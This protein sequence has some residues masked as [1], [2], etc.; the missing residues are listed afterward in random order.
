MQIRFLLITLAFTLLSSCA[1]NTVPF[2]TENENTWLLEQ[3]GGDTYPIYCMA[4]KKN[5]TADPV[6]YKARKEYNKKTG[7]LK[8]HSP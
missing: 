5:E 4:N 6:C 2:A 3:S 7:Q 8:F 1:S